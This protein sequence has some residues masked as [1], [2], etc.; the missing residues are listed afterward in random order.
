MTDSHEQG[1]AEE[2][3]TTLGSNVRTVR[4]LIGETPNVQS[5][6]DITE[7]VMEER[8]AKE[9]PLNTREQVLR[10]L[11]MEKCKVTGVSSRSTGKV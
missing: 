10:C 2:E 9:I 8:R 11:S 3:A 6:M 1:E 7:A 4:T 5:I